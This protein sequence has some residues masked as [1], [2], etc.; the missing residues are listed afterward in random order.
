[1][2]NHVTLDI[3]DICRRQTKQENITQHRKLK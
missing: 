3:Q 1:M 2:E